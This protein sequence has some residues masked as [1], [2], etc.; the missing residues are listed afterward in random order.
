MVGF[1][2]VKDYVHRLEDAFDRLRSR[3]AEVSESLQKEK[4]ARRFEGGEGGPVVA[5]PPGAD[6]MREA[7]KPTVRRPAPQQP[8]PAAEQEDFASRLMKA[9]KK[10]MEGREPKKEE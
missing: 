4:A 7:P 1:T 8:E 9:K 10:A 2:R 5:P 6:E 3:K